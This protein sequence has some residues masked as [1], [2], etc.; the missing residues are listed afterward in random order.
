MENSG[1]KKMNLLALGVV[2]DEEVGDGKDD[3]GED[4]ELNVFGILGNLVV[5]LLLRND[6]V[7]IPSEGGKDGVPGTGTNSGVEQELSEVH[8]S[9]SC[10]DA[11]EVAYAWDESACQGCCNAM[12][13][14]ITL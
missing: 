2:P 12:L 13:I 3:E 10:R 1:D 14:E 11:D 6:G 8:A 5:E 4:D 7:E 9:Q